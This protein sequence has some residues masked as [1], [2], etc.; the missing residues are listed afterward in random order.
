MGG[1]KENGCSPYLSWVNT[2]HLLNPRSPSTPSENAVKFFDPHP[3]IIDAG[4][5]E[6]LPPQPNQ[7]S[8]PPTIDT[9]K[10]VESFFQNKS[11]GT[12]KAYKQDM[13]SFVKFIGATTPE[14]AALYLLGH[15]QGHAN[16][17][18]LQFKDHLKE[19]KMAPAS[20]NRKLA[21]LKSLCKLGRVVGLVSFGLEVEGFEVSPLRDTRGPGP[22]NVQKLLAQAEKRTDKKGRRDY[23]MLRLMF[24]LA[25]RRGEVCSLD[26][27]HVD[28]VQGAVSIMGK[29]R[30]QREWLSLPDETRDAIKS[31]LS[32]RGSEPGPLMIALDPRAYGKRLRGDGAALVIG[33]M[34]EGI[35]ARVR[36]H[37]LRHAAITEALNA[38]DGNLRLVQKYSRHRSLDMLLV[39]DDARGDFGGQV[40][41][42]VAKR[43]GFDRK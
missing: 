11:E 17:T 21:A 6:L 31:W 8:T 28:L 9:K 7:L 34:G 43:S 10:L 38:T 25:M 24:D 12:K 35:G 32:V 36:P 1:D 29:G 3:K 18:A 33:K 37:G 14:E 39:Y 16:H 30:S 19:K 15:G 40:A 5:M 2:P 26:V 22:E 13:K 42:M 23:A 41:R 27:E 4:L 20:I